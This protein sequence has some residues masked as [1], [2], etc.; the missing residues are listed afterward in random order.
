MLPLILMGLGVGLQA[1]GQIQQA[2]AA[3]AAAEYN[4]RVAE[5]NAVLAE[6]QAAAEEDRQRRL[7]YKQLSAMRAGYGA[8]GV[9]IEGSPLDVLEESAANAELD[10][11]TIRHAGQVRATAYRQ[12][13]AL[14]RYRGKAATRAGYISAAST[15][16]TG[17][18]EI[19]SMKRSM[20]QTGGSEIP[21]VKRTG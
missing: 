16:L 20:G 1:L 17:G 14:E 9:S 13:A 10:A 21:R 8:A 2:Q 15:L 3:R 7:S 5:M 19:L 4:A 6:Q 11:L 18:G 12:E